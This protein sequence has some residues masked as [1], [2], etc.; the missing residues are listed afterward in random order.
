MLTWQEVLETEST[1]DS[2][3]FAEMCCGI[4]VYRH[5]RALILEMPHE[6]FRVLSNGWHNGGFTDSPK[7][8]INKTSLGGKLEWIMMGS[9]D[10]VRKSTSAYFRKLGYDPDEVVAE[11]TA[12]GMD[13]A[14]IG[15]VE[16]G[17]IRMSVA[18][19]AGIRGN[20]GCAGDPASYDEGEAHRMK[21]GTI[22]VL[23]VTDAS[24]SDSAML[25]VQTVITQAKSSVIEELQAKSLYSH[26]L[27]TGSGTDQIAVISDRTSGNAIDDFRS[28]SQ[29][30][31]TLANLVRRELYRA[32]DM[33]SWMTLTEQCDA[34]T[35]LSR[36]G[37][38][39][40][41]MQDEIRSQMR[42]RD[43]RTAERETD[44]DPYVVAMFTSVLRI[45]DAIDAGLTDPEI[46]LAT[47]KKITEGTLGDRV[48]DDPLFRL[49]A[50]SSET[51][52]ELLSFYLAM[53]IER[54][55]GELKGVE[56]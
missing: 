21:N 43:L 4:P 46:G 14:A 16:A 30:A 3:L 49:R 37:I 54:R 53:M 24:L 18:I 33:Q 12:A 26:R 17:G 23:F 45:Q 38:T 25:K 34:M 15:S 2:R 35:Q 55:A 11:G 31:R 41:E 19:T 50:E 40:R 20:G 27:A 52:P 56:S 51:I 44:R 9:M 47:A 1:D 8:V 48:P 7:A 42:F 29:F 5:G 32:F 36:F 22:V 28:D 6:G 39:E 10:E 13:N